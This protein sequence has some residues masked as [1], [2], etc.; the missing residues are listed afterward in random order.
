MEV[1]KGKIFSLFHGTQGSR[2]LPT[3]VWLKADK[4]IVRDGS[5]ATWYE[6]GFHV[7]KSIEAT[8]IFLDKMFRHKENRRVIQCEATGLR[9]KTHSKGDV[10]L[11]DR[12]R[13]NN[14]YKIFAS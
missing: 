14:S 12:M 7:L 4:K 9:K 8:K 3:G 13:I 5:C 10:Y 1:K 11:A 2:N 6:S